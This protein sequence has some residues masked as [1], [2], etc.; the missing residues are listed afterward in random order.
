VGIT[1]SFN[2][3]KLLGL[4]VKSGSSVLSGH[5]YPRC[6]SRRDIVFGVIDFASHEVP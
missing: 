5:L 6:I 3:S 1:G 2:K 4:V